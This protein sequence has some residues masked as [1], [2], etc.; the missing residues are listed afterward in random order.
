MVWSGQSIRSKAMKLPDFSHEQQELARILSNTDR[1]CRVLDVGCG[2]GRNLDLLR[3]LG[4]SRIVGADRNPDLV[5]SNTARGHLCFTP[6]M[7][8]EENVE[9]FDLI[10]MSHIVEHF[11]HQALLTFLG[12]YLSRLRVGGQLLIVTPLPHDAF[13]ND[14]DHVR[15]YL[16]MGFLM[17]FGEGQAQVQYQSNDVLRLQDLRFYRCPFRLQFCRAFYVRRASTLPIWINRLL[18]LVFLLSRG[19]LGQRLGWM[20]LY[21]YVGPR[22]KKREGEPDRG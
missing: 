4:F 13:Y 11:D 17:V 16:P 5:S 3:E 15:P 19:T 1:G 9:P 12:C 18:R 8:D 22:V 14:F 10:L 7:L 20:G 6:E 21:E 2:T